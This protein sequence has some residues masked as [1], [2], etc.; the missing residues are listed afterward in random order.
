MES[1]D[2]FKE[3]LKSMTLEELAFKLTLHRGTLNRWL[4]LNSVPK[5][6]FNDLN[7]LLGNKY[8][9]KNE[10]RDKD[11]FFTSQETALFCIKK[12]KMILKKLGLKEAEYTYIEPSAGDSSF[13]SLLPRKRRIGIDIDPKGKLKNELLKHDYLAYFPPQNNK[14]IIIGNP[15]FGL[16][17]NLALRFINHSSNFAD[18]VAFIL[19]PLF[20]STG[21]GVPMKRI[22]NYKLAFSEPL[23]KNSFYYPNGN[24]VDVTTIFQIWTKVS[25]DKLT[26]KEIKTCDNYA[27]VYSL[28]DGGT[29]SSTRN[30][31]MLNKCDIY[32]PSTCF[33][34]MKAY[35]SFEK[36]PQRRG[37]GVIFKKNKDDLIKLFFEKIEWQKVAF[38]S[39]NGALNLRTDLILNQLID[40][41]YFD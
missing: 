26:I 8:E 39:T 4:L 22:V 30:K 20:D 7:S 17:G 11:Q 21:K 27:R 23:P 6:Y 24:P 1:I 2:L 32:L 29:P 25:F 41:G 14:Y 37:Y 35:D 34:G 15:P 16:R 36:L 3:L 18:I 13:Y 40:Y 12:T 9:T 38:Y 5:N 28:S 33:T 19:P 31:N 10:F